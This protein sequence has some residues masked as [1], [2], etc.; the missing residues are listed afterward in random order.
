[1]SKYPVILFE[2][3]EGSGKTT[4]INYVCNY[5]KRNKIKFIKI[6]EPGGCKNSEKIRKLILDKKSNFNP[7]TDLLLYLASRS[8]NIEKIFSKNYKKK[9]IL[10]D[11]FYYSTFAYQHYGMGINHNIIKNINSHIL[12][13]FK[14]DYIFLHTVKLKTMERRLKKRRDNNRYDYFNNSFYKRVQNGFLKMLKNKK[15]V[16]IINSSYDI[17]KNKNEILKVIKKLI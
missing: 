8:E 3:I 1:M 16:K 4:Q 14:P 6:R 15:N 13:G 9:I 17:K 11:R 7:T 5:L 12:N 10:I 2:G